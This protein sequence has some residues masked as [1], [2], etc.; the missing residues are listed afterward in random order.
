MKAKSI[1]GKSPEEIRTALQKSVS[2]GFKA[3]LAL[4]FISVKQD[5]E[6]IV[7]ILDKLVLQ[8]MVLH[9]WRIH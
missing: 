3:S 7:E 6:A 9:K 4:V 8:S 5:R 1:K 2:D